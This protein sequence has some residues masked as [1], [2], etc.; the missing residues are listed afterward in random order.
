MTSIVGIRDGHRIITTVTGRGGTAAINR[1]HHPDCPCLSHPPQP[2]RIARRRK[3][4][5]R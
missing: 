3:P 1:Q 2:P 5:R 4:T